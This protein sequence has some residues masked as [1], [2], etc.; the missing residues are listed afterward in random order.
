MKYNTLPKILEGLGKAW[1]AAW[2][3]IPLAVHV[4]C[5]FTLKHKCIASFLLGM[6]VVEILH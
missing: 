6:L 4:A 3:Q 2:V 1:R 5:L